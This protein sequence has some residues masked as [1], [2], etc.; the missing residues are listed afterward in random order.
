MHEQAVLAHHKAVQ[1]QV[2]QGQ[3]LE[4]HLRKLNF[5]EHRLVGLGKQVLEGGHILGQGGPPKAGG[6]GLDAIDQGGGQAHRG[7]DLGAL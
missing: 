1:G 2:Q 3:V 7:G 5:A 4:A 6:V